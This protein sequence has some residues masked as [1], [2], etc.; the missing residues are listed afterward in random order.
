MVLSFV[1]ATSR[2][3][4]YSRQSS[5]LQV[6]IVMLHNSGR[7]TVKNCCDDNDVKELEVQGDQ[8]GLVTNATIMFL[9][10]IFSTCS[11]HGWL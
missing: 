5:I 6:H 2:N 4:H 8:V 1:L 7:I 11:V 10:S 3:T 9:P